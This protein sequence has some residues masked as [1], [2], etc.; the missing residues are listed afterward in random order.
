MNKS[1]K[2]AIYHNCILIGD[3]QSPDV[4]QGAI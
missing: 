4:Y 1:H 2:Y 3:K